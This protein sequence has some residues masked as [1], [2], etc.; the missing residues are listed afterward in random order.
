MEERRRLT[1]RRV[2]FQ[3]SI[4]SKFRSVRSSSNRASVA[5]R[6]QLS[7]RSLVYATRKN[8]GVPEPIRSSTRTTT[9][10]TQDRQLPTVL[11]SSGSLTP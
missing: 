11:S 7:A 5:I 10:T 6:A 2:H 8:A 1:V 4:A 3:R 9:A